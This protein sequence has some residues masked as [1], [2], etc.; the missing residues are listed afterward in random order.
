V[1]AAVAVLHRDRQQLPDL[2]AGGERRVRPFDGEPDIAADERQRRVRPQR[3]G[4]QAGLAEDLEAVADSQ[5]QPALPRELDDRRHRRREPRD[6]TAAE[7]VAVREAAREDDR[8]NG[9]EP[10]VAVPRERGL[11][12]ELGQRVR[13]VAVV[14]RA[15][16]DDDG[17]ARSPPAHNSVSVIA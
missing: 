3:A 16:E 13:R 10:L 9:R 12:P 17:N 11:G 7:V 4:Q 8:V 5:H 14:V 2:A 6:R 1:P 15:R